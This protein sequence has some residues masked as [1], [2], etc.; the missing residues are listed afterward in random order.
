VWSVLE[1]GG[2]L[3]V[4]QLPYRYYPIDR[5]TTGLPLIN[6]LPRAVALRYAHARSRRI[7]SDA[8]WD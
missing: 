2:V 6:Y 7:S 5:H 3:L 8:D 1:P 4:S